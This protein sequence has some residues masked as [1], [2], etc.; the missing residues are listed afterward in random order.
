MSD[1]FV[2]KLAEILNV[3]TAD[4][5]ASLSEL[6]DEIRK[7][8][9]DR[10]SVAIPRLGTFRKHEEGIEFEPDAEIE[11]YVNTE[12]AG[13]APVA[14]EAGA[15]E[16]LKETLG[17]SSRQ[18]SGTDA[19]ERIDQEEDVSVEKDESDKKEAGSG[20]GDRVVDVSRQVAE[21]LAVIHALGKE[22][23]D[24]EA[25]SEPGDGRETG[26]ESSSEKPVATEKEAGPEPEPDAMP[27]PDGEGESMTA[28]ETETES[29][30][31]DAAKLTEEET[32]SQEEPPVERVK[33]P[34][35]EKGKAEEPEVDKDSDVDEPVS[36]KEE[37]RE[38]ENLARSRRARDIQ[39]D[40]MRLRRQSRSAQLERQAKRNRLIIAA[41]AVLVIVI[42]GWWA[43]TSLLTGGTDAPLDDDYA[44]A[45]T[46]SVD[47]RATALSVDTLDSELGN[48]DSVAA[49][50]LQPET[51]AEQPAPPAERAS[52][53][54]IPGG[55]GNYAWI[56]G[57][58]SSRAEA[59]RVLQ[60]YTRA[61][62]PG[63]LVEATLDGRTYY[64][65]AIGRFRTPEAAEAARQQLPDF[66]PPDMWIRNI[67]PPN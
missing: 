45:G 24:E 4:A 17:K 46:E 36:A 34:K 39:A 48:A 14:V 7:Q 29:A 21:E 58:S 13:L 65:I 1:S 41:S 33:E 25:A 26:F 5:E 63:E 53:D 42:L 67:G 22:M 2:Q 56:V 35:L 47:Q 62:V 44:A 37:T 9:G 51:P 43:V 54:R 52:P 15:A 10:G 57:S 16:R 6:V 30:Q 49:G 66:A 59:E 11:S 19:Q 18:V 23:V 64:R 60:R 50:P 40:A 31:F 8:L 12:F 3:G 55:D 38:D 20:D 61:G 27:A 32:L 28:D